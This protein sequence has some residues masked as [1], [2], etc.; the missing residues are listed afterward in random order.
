M[1]S[2]PLTYALIPAR[3]RPPA[4]IIQIFALWMRI[5]MTVIRI[6]LIIVIVIPLMPHLMLLFV[7][8]FPTIV[9]TMW[10]VMMV[11][12]KQWIPALNMALMIDF[13]HMLHP[14]KLMRIVMTAMMQQ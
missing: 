10:I 6:R 8:Q 2:I 3:R 12:Q 4:L 5:A 13:V 9:K 11:I 1:T 7:L 14:V